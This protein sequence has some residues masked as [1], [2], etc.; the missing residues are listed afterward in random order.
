MT[1]YDP[2]VGSG[3]F[4]F[5]ACMAMRMALQK[6]G[7]PD[8]NGEVTRDII[9]RQLFAQDISPMAVQVTRLRL[10]I[11]IVAQ[12]DAAQVSQPP[13]PNLEGR[14]I[15]ADT[16]A[17]NPKGWSPERQGNTLGSNNANVN[18]ALMRRAQVISRWLTAHAED[19]KEQIRLDDVAARAALKKA[20]GRS[21][22]HREISH[23][24]DADL[25]NPNAAPVRIDPR[26]LFYDENWRGFDIVI[27]NPPYETFSKADRGWTNDQLKQR[28]Y[29]TTKG[30]DLYNLIAEAALT[31]AKPIHGVVTLIVPLSLS[32]GQDQTDT[33]I[34][35]ESQASDIWLR[36]Q[37]NRPDK[38]F[39]ESPVKS[40]ENRQRTTI[41]TALTGS[42]KP[43]LRTTGANKWR[44]FEREEYM[45]SRRY[46][47]A[48]GTN[49]HGDL[50][51]QWPRLPSSEMV[52]LV[53]A[54]NRQ[55]SAV[56]SLLTS[57][58]TAVAR[59]GLPMSTYQFITV[60]PAGL[61]KREESILP[62]KDQESLELAM[63]ALNGHIAY[64]W[65]RIYGDAYHLKPTEMATVAVPDQ[66]LGD[67]TA[68]LEAR[69]L[70]R[71][72]IDAITP[73]NI[74]EITTG[75]NSTKQDS[76]NFHECVPDVIAQIDA[77]YLDAL[78]LPPNEL[79]DQMQTLRSDS[80]WHLGTDF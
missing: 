15:C 46:A 17:T 49:R 16:L 78:G 37:D 33:R 54:M 74:G 18:D 48:A 51:A 65:W 24:A 4:P 7:V 64:A 53:Q 23:F 30:N 58:S 5:T 68:N 10:F 39:H 42:G 27:G 11:A 63:A 43:R 6:L 76:L 41:I 29:T 70:G 50:R 69:R 34:L 45:L 1:I 44:R 59:A 72:L 61:M 77:L 73:E 20:A 3:E 19:K 8:N 26:I 38:T 28:G 60:T 75:T 14:V 79:M 57:R 13:L 80:S 56:A 36:H 31:L 55:Q 35:F 2:A 12:E 52:Y 25:L 67:I 32:F 9:S 40:R 62:F 71:L 21:P 47:E 22:L 66:W